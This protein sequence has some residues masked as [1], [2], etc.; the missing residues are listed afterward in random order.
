MK[1]FSFIEKILID[2]KSISHNSTTYVIAEAG[3]ARFGNL[4]KAFRLVDLAKNAG[5]DAVKFQAYITDELI[6]NQFKKWYDRYKLKEIN[7]S[8]LSK[9]K[10]YCKKKKI[11]FLFTPHSETAIEWAKKLNIPAIKVGSGEIGNF[12]FLSQIIK[13]K[14]PIIISTGMHNEKDLKDLSHFF[15]SKNFKKVI[16]LRCV[17]SYPTKINELNLRNLSKFKKIFKNAIVGYSDHTNSDLAIYFAVSNGAKL[18]EKHISLDFNVKNA[19]DWKV[20]HDEIRMKNL[21][22]NIRNLEI[23]GGKLNITPSKKE[24]SNK[25]WATKS[26]FYKNRFNKGQ[27]LTEDM[28]CAKRP[29]TGIKCSELKKYLG[30]KLNKNTPIRMIK[31]SD[32][33]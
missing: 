25:I 26:L 30:K 17:T 19:Q 24:L 2:K 1:N 11:T 9:I 28:I 15:I 14:R 8:F 20:S 32:F 13:L 33:K 12:K 16:F 31:K 10:K 5:A 7:Y 6:F 4:K 22:K 23:I 27:V 3:V 29:G 21:I 18:I